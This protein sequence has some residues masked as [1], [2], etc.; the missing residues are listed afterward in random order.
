MN[1][2][3]VENVGIFVSSL[4]VGVEVKVRRAGRGTVDFPSCHKSDPLCQYEVSDTL[5]EVLQ[6]SASIVL[7]VMLGWRPTAQCL[8][9]PL[10][11]ECCSLVGGGGG[12][13]VRWCKY[14][15]S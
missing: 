8:R 2:E 6:A 7:L 3:I 15:G 11:V 1:E 4:V 13:P 5:P 14:Y 9:S 10:F 12:L